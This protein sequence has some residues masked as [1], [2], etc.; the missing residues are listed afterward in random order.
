MKAFVDKYEDRIHGVLSCF[1][2]MLFRGYLP[3]MSGWSMAQLLQAHEIDCGSVK[4]FLLANAE[5]VKAHAL[6]LARKHGRPFEYLS[7]KLRK[8]DAA[9]KIAE[10][11]GIDEGLVCVFSALEPCRTFSLRFT[12]GQPYVQSAK[13][14]CLHLYYYFMDRDLGLFTFAF[15]P[16]SRCRSRSTSTATSGWIVSSRPAVSN[17][18]RSTTSL[19]RLIDLPRAQ[20]L[21]D[22]FAHLNWPQILNRYARRVVPQLDD[23]LRGCEYYWVAAQAEYATDVMFKTAEGLR[24]L[25]PRLLSHSTLCFDAKEVMNFLG[26]KLVGNFQGEVVSDLSSLVCRRT[27][28]SRIKHRVKQNW[29]KMYDKAGLVLRVETVINNPEEFRVR[30][31]VLRDGKQR[32]EWVQLRKGVAYL[33]RYREVSLQANARY[34]DALAAVDDPTKGKQALQRL[35]A[36]KKDA[37]GRSCPGF[38]PMAQHDATLFKSLMDGEHCLRGFTN[39]DIRSQLTKHA[40]AARV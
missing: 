4:P 1:D 33:F 9:R 11:D 25:Y 15:R 7:A 34:L 27:G 40:L 36:A 39:R 29:L 8:E 12:T 35:T 13:R 18:R 31:Q 26:R 6:A 37:A 24:E 17:T 14:K 38:N 23:V 20:R 3:I 19:P 22:R 10:R 32:A 30:K 16:G 28:G 5:R 21:A 2:R